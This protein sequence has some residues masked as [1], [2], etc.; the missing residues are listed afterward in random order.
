M[1]NPPRVS[2]V[3]AVYNAER[4]L[5]QAVRSI[6]DQTYGDF[7]LIIIDDGSTDGSPAMLKSFADG[8]RRLNVYRQPNSGLITS[9]N[10]ACGLARGTYVARMDA[11]DISLPRRFEK[12]VQHL[13]ARKEIGVLGTWIQDIGADGQPGPIWPLPTSPA[14][15]P[16]FLMFGNCLAHPSVMMRRELIQSLAYRTEAIHVEDYDLWIRASSMTGVA[17]IPEVLLKYRILNQSVSSRHLAVQETQAAAL[18]RGL[19]QQLLGTTEAVEPVTAE[20]LLKLY[21]AYR[22][23]HSLDS[24]AES[25][26][27]LD[28]LRRL[29]LSRELR[30]ALPRVL[31]LFPRLFSLQAVRKVLRYGV[32]YAGNIQHGFTTQRRVPE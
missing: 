13:D 2:G 25:E 1:G 15:I 23:K 12:Q 30:Q 4:Y 20:M 11:D 24:G 5:E 21:G 31:P 8:D 28:V 32:S 7:E 18:Q 17:N 16:W 3:M 27:A 6:L 26:I 10:K 29:Y 14:T 19:R 9:L 22:R